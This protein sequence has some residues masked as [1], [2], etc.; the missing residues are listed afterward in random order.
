MKTD[1]TG[2][3]PGIPIEDYHRAP[4]LGATGIGYFLEAPAVFKHW[5]DNPD[6]EG[7]DSTETGSLFHC[8]LLE[9]DVFASKYVHIQGPMN[10]NPWKAEADAV[11]AARKIPVGD[12]MYRNVIGMRD[13]ALAQP[14]IQALLRGATLEHSV[15]WTDPTH[16][17]PKKC[18]PDA[19]QVQNR[20]ITDFKSI[21]DV[22]TPA[23][24]K[25]AIRKWRYGIKAKHY[26]DG[27]S[28]AVGEKLNLF[29]HVFIQNTAPYLVGYCAFSDDDLARS[30]LII[31]D[32][33]RRYAQCLETDTWPGLTDEVVPIAL[34]YW[35]YPEIE[36]DL[37]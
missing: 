8:A 9:P 1:L 28:I 24:M 12:T 29:L 6:T 21:S 33:S 34:D 25:K 36:G 7:T 13:A 2:L 16:G 3:I 30:A 18:R 11:K 20:L 10:K 4:G 5:R 27:C 15:F 14:R 37:L 17:F 26:I 23:N 35:D 19:L 22:P 31:D 32:V